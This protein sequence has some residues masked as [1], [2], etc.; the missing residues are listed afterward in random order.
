VCEL[1]AALEGFREREDDLQRERRHRREAGE[2]RRLLG[3]A[4]WR[5]VEQVV[6]FRELDDVSARL[7]Q[8]EL[9]P[10][11]AADVIVARTLARRNADS[12]P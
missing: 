1:V 8:R 6:G 9:D 12:K 7:A 2:L 10:Y 3:E 11:S 5:H 4:F